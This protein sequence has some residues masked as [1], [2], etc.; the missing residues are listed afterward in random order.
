[1]KAFILAAGEGTR[2]R[3]YTEKVPKCLV[4]IDGRPLLGIWIDLMSRHGVS[5]ILI[6]THYRAGEVDAFIRKIRDHVPVALTTVY[7]ESLLGSAGT[8]WHNKGFVDGEDEFIIAYGD[9]LTDIN[10]TGMMHCHRKH[11]SR[12]GI[13]TVG[14]FHA[15]DPSACGIA[16]LGDGNRIVDFVEKPVSPRSDM[17]NGGIY[18]ASPAIFEAVEDRER[19][20]G[21][22]AFDFGFHVLPAL[23]GRM[24]GY[25]IREYLR[26]IGTIESYQAARREW[27]LRGRNQ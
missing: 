22:P 14:L 19:G 5:D 6:N 23:V 11:R 1:M 15:P 9:N 26:D 18:V 21:D 13:L 2:L 4:P 7:E 3:P 25:E 20:D 24:H 8:V 27:P 10:L 12:G 16:V 17:A